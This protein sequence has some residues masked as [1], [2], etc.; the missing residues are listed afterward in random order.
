MAELE[1]RITMMVFES[2][3]LEKYYESHSSSSAYLLRFLKYKKPD[4]YSDETNNVKPIAHTD[5]SFMSILHQ[6]S[7]RG[8]EVQT[9]DGEW[10]SFEPSPSSFMVMAGN[11]C[12]VS[13]IL[14]TLATKYLCH[15][16]VD[17]YTTF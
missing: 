7:V 4:S 10:L 14:K 8:L 3:G 1:Q 6:N 17:L 13:L 16:A 15:V 2:Y 9:K 11:A 12:V 5:K